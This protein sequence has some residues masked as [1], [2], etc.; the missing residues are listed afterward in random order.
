MTAEVARATSAADPLA[1]AE[2][3][4]ATEGARERLLKAALDL[5][6][7]EGR[8]AVS[9]RAVS[10][11]AGVRAP[12]LYR[13][14]GDKEGLLDAVGTYG[15]QGYLADKQALDNASEGSGDPLADLRRLWELHV[16][17]G[18]AQPALYTLVYGEARQ[19]KQS[20]AA[21]QS[22]AITRR[23][24]ARIAAAGQ[25]RMSV[26]RATQFAHATGVGIVLSLIATPPADRDPGLPAVVAEHVLRAIATGEPPRP[27]M[28]TDT[29]S[30]AAALQE[31]LQASDSTALTATESA[32]L[33]E[34]LTRIANAGGA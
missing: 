23:F 13:L 6:I 25:L 2:P 22:V 34:W 27:S 15:F 3:V 17:F 18:L 11:A 7:R 20:P 21:Q 9:T 19:G 14:F 8:G 5:L 30:R 26:P 33:G 4:E 24:I 16:E 1:I 29:A 28:A 32:L 31:A 10:A 12:A